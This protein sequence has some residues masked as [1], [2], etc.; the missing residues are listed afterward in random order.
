MKLFVIVACMATGILFSCHQQNSKNKLNES[1]AVSRSSAETGLSQ[2]DQV[3]SPEQ[4]KLKT[5]QKMPPPVPADWNKQIIRNAELSFEVKDITSVS[6]AVVEA[7]RINGGYIASSSEVQLSGELKNE[8][9]IRVPREKFEE[10]LERL[11]G[12]G[13][14]ILQKNVTSED[15]TAEYIDTKARISAKEKVKEKYYDFLK[16]ARNIDEVLKVQNEIGSLQEDI[17]AASGRVNYIQHQAALSTIH[18]SFFQLMLPVIKP[19]ETP[20]FWKQ[21]LY[22]AKEGWD[23]MQ[24]LVIA[25]VRIWPLWLS[26]IFIWIILKKKKTVAAVNSKGQVLK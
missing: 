20:G 18:L 6:K 8:M 14:S 10:L 22:A 3:P 23:I 2:L 15:V 24:L 21:A 13:D 19:E 9:T 11:S 16:Q 17:E 12:Y 26:G 7:V 25:I 1:G 4:A 5:D